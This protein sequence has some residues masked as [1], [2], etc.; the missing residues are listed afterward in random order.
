MPSKCTIETQSPSLRGSG[1]FRCWRCWSASAASG[2][3]PLHCG[4]VVASRGGS[5]RAAGR[6]EDSIPFIAGQ[7]SLLDIVQ[8][9]DEKTLVT[10]SP[11]LRGSGRFW[12]KPNLTRRRLSRLNP[13]H[14]GAV[15]ASDRSCGAGCRHGRTQSP[16]LRGSGRFTHLPPSR[17]EGPRDSIPF[18]AG[19]W[20]LP[21]R[22]LPSQRASRRDSIPFIAGQWSLPPLAA[23]RGGK[24]EEDS[25]PFIAGQWSLR[26]RVRAGASWRIP[27]SIPFIA[28]QWSLRWQPWRFS[29]P[30]RSTQS[31]SLRGSGRFMIK[32]AAGWDGSP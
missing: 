17:G 7:W 26:W 25:I 4:A 16:S 6:R 24:E 11:S 3:N 14:C 31:P 15:V 1:R 29:S 23:R 22:R 5:A 21:P 20:S 8:R 32:L 28:G 18:I 19:Q 30:P 12:P 27:D 2:L 10:Q 13:L 9:V